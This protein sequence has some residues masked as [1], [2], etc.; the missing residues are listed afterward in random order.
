VV[1]GEMD[2]VVDVTAVVLEVDEV[3]VG[4]TAVAR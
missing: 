1:L 4:V 3:K 2:V